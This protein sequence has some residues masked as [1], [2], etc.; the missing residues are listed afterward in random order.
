MKNTKD[1][2]KIWYKFYECNCHDEGIMMSYDYE[3]EAIPTIDLGFFKCGFS[4]ARQPLTFKERC[5]WI[6]NIITK[7]RPFIDSVMLSQKTAKELAFDLLEFY[8]INYKFGD[9]NENK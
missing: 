8:N 2:Q 4:N 5:E 7:G 3:E 1:P 6:W 9:K